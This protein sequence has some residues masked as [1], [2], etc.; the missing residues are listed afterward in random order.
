MIAT[1]AMALVTMLQLASDKTEAVYSPTPDWSLEY[2]IR[3]EPYVQGY[4]ECLKSGSYVIGDGRRF[5]EQYTDDI[6]RCADK[7]MAL[8]K[9]A[10]SSLEGRKSGK[11]T[12]P[13]EV[14]AI[15]EKVRMIHLARGRSLDSATRSS[16]T[17]KPEYQAVMQR[18]V[19]RD[20]EEAA[21]CVARLK[22]LVAERDSF[23]AE[24]EASIA[25]LYANSEYSESDKQ[26]LRDYQ[27]RLQRLNNLIMIEQR[28]C[29]QAGEQEIADANNAQD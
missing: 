1:T 14:A 27:G 7:G 17:S 9:E 8:E 12:P 29:P 22:S 3:I 20:G 25:D 5:E 11:D 23:M 28:R 19:A 26:A 6:A 16:L 15:F 2:P 21:R 10:N 13:A 18:A 4:Y 24:E